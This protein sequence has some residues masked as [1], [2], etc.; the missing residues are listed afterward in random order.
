MR[1]VLGLLLVATAVTVIASISGWWLSPRRR[2]ARA[3]R[4]RL[5]GRADAVA[6]SPESARGVGISAEKASVAVVRFAGDP[7]RIYSLAAVFGV[8][9]M[10]DGE[11]KARA[12]R[13]E[14]RRALDRID[15]SVEGRVTLRLI[16]EDAAD[17]AFEIDLWRPQDRPRPGWGP[18]A[19]LRE[20]RGL[21]DRLE[22]AAR[23]P[24]EGIVLR[25]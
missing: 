7:G 1:F 4:R 13:G 18:D 23:R 19:A 9:L 5:G 10:L 2:T 16:L 12:F 20:A 17:P 11:V 25:P 24:A 8:E 6:V 15:P 22:A 3:V 14:G 21:Y